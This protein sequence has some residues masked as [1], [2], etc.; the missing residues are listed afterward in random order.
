MRGE[1]ARGAA[2]GLGPRRTASPEGGRPLPAHGR[3]M[4]FSRN[5]KGGGSRAE[6]AAAGR[7]LP[8]ACLRRARRHCILLASPGVL[9]QQGEEEPRVISQ[10][11]GGRAG[12]ERS[13]AR[14]AAA[15]R[16]TALPPAPARARASP[17]GRV[18]AHR[19]RARGPSVETAALRLRTQLSATAGWLGRPCWALEQ[20][21]QGSRAQTCPVELMASERDTLQPASCQGPTTH[22]HT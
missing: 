22:I 18:P 11:R 9:E 16:P 5:G 7:A 1:R 15:V 3:L 2:G 20:G 4:A 10:S 8:P 19:T 13:G 17:G 14:A 6:D 21:S 12:G